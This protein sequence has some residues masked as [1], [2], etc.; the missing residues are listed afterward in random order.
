MRQWLIDAFSQQPFGGN[1]ACIVEPLAAWPAVAWMQSLAAENNVGATAFLK[2]TPD[3][4]RFGLRWF[5][6]ATEV[7]LCGHATLAGA[8]VLFVETGLSAD[9]L[10][11]ETQGGVL[12]VSRGGAD[13]ELSMPLLPSRQIEPPF[14]LAEALGAE[15]LA[16]W[17]GHYLI[18]LLHSAEAVRQLSPRLE[19]IEAISRRLDGKG[20][21]GVAA[22]CEGMNGPD[23]IDRFFAPG[24][25]LPEDPATGSFHAQLAPILSAR[26]DRPELSYHQAYPGRGAHIGARVEG[27]QVVLRGGAVTV[28]ESWL[29]VG[30]SAG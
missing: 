1:Q 28:A 13:Y 6:P 10:R 12:T 29:R 4:G 9:R 2:R 25:G 3:P 27:E 22:L 23:V 7:P 19:A 20:N 11:F 18:A 24:F 26:L 15:L 14:G 16:V 8:H 30:S 5:T 17:Q 21:V